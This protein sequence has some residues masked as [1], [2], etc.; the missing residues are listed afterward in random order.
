MIQS[1]KKSNETHQF[2]NRLEYIPKV[3]AFFQ[4][5]ASPFLIGLLIGTIIYLS[6]PS[7]LRLFL[8]ILVAALGLIVGIIWAIK[9]W[10]GSGTVDF[11]AITM[12]T[13]ELDKKD[14]AVVLEKK[15]KGGS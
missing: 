2:V 5:L 13:P 9:K 10:K 11:M 15:A 7:T 4:I 6:H 12:A 8:V 1:N 3:I 14:D